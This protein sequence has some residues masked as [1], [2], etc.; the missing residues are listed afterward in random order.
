MNGKNDMRGS[1]WRRWDLHIHAPG[2]KLN[3]AY[4]RVDEETWEKFID[5]LEESP[6]SVFGVTDYFSCD[7]YYE[8]KR[9]YEERF[10]QTEKVFFPNIEFRLSESISKDG[11]HP[12]IHVIFDNDEGKAP[13]EKIER[14]LINLEIQDVDHA[15]AKVRCIDLEGE[16]QFTAATV[17]LDGLTKALAET[18]G[19]EKPYLLAFPAN[20]NGLRSTDS[21]SPRKIAL[22][23]RIDKSCH[24][25]FGGAGNR[26]YLLRPDRYEKGSSD[27]KPVVSGSD[28]HSFDDL[29]RLSGDT[30]GFPA[31]WIKADPTFL[32]LK[33]ICHEPESRIFIGETPDAATR[34]EQDGTKFIESLKINQIEGYEEENGAWFKDVTIPINPE[35]TAVIGNKGSGKSAIIDIIGLL[36]N[37][38]QE[39][40]FSFLADDTKSKKFRRRGYSE[41]FVASITWHAG[42]VD[43]KKLD[44]ACDFDLPE[45]VEYLP[46]NYFEQLTNEIEIEQFRAEIED[47]VF[48]HV[49]ETERLG[50]ASFSELEISKTQKSKAEIGALKLKLSALNAEIS[51][52]EE[53]VSPHFRRR[54]CSQLE[55]KRD[56]IA[57]L[58]KAKPT[59][60][61]KPDTETE[62][63][64]A[65]AARVDLLGHMQEG[66]RAEGFRLTARAT[67]LKKNLQWIST[68][69]EQIE[70]LKRQVDTVR[71]DIS[72]GLAAV[73]VDLDQVVKLTI[74]FAPIFNAAEDM[75]DELKLLESLNVTDFSSDFDFSQ[76]SSIPDLRLAYDFL[77]REMGSAMEQLSTPQ[78]RYQAYVDR[79]ASWNAKRTDMIGEVAPPPAGTLNALQSQLNYIDNDLRRILK[80]RYDARKGIVEEIFRSKSEILQFYRDLKDSVDSR[81]KIVRDQGF[82]IAISASFILDRNFRSD[83]LHYVDQRKKGPFRPAHEA[84]KTLGAMI[85]NTNWDFFESVAEFCQGIISRMQEEGSSISDQSR[86]I[87]EMYDYLF[88]LDYIFPRYELRL[89][90]KNL[91]ELSPGEKGLL[92]LVFYLQL[93]QKDTPLIIDQPEDNLD[94]ASIFSVLAGCIREAKKRRQVVLVTHNPNLAVGADAE[95]IVYVNL[96]KPKNYKFTYEAGAIENPRLNKRIIDILEGSQ[97]AFVKRRLKYGIM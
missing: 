32:G 47:V 14:F 61:P 24:L 85:G 44:E 72:P 6:V 40:Y 86:D 33:Q 25:F 91:N 71:A 65:L 49:E 82:N 90:G 20:N 34:L 88:S 38:R 59:E 93:D 79:L 70:G 92:L 51:E 77:R 52:L 19:S 37:S 4:G 84:E 2:T 76:L 28:A 60:V 22:A 16:A 36:G 26:E 97:P 54:I 21:K 95:Q 83:F 46:Q 63:Q 58:E 7:N 15:S 75:R 17:T 39:N 50:A 23:D 69:Q 87:G 11:S 57:A 9:R 56:E 55:A 68:A 81:L 96:D 53:Q 1:L 10:P 29:E 80:E 35:L 27:P 74:D 13:R 89:D 12:D 94:N 3:N 45:T 78:R 62:E 41:N 48:S 42:K 31:T 8:F 30:A 18:F 64:K 5:K 66:I 73:G 67:E 43:E